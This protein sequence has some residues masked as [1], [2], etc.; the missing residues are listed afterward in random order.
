M[1]AAIARG[2]CTSGK[3][4]PSWWGLRDDH[5][6]MHNIMIILETPST[7]KTCY[8][9]QQSSYCHNMWWTLSCNSYRAF[10]W[11]LKSVQFFFYGYLAVSLAAFFFFFAEFD[12]YLSAIICTYITIEIPAN[13]TPRAFVLLCSAPTYKYLCY[14]ITFFKNIWFWAKQIHSCFLSH[15]LPTASRLQ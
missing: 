2:I 6:K 11:Y 1:I 14:S 4:S 9:S 12:F 13:T 3:F 15:Y 10:W 7:N 8:I 5:R